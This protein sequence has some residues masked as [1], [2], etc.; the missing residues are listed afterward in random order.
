MAMALLLWP[1]ALLLLL[2]ASEALQAFS[3]SR[4]LRRITSLQAVHEVSSGN[5]VKYLLTFACYNLHIL[6]F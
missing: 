1:L 4:T 5:P 2:A 6:S 3:K